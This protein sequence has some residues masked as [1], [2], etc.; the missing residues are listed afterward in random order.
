MIRFLWTVS[1]AELQK[2]ESKNRSSGDFLVSHSWEKCTNFMFKRKWECLGL[3]FLF[4]FWSWII[5]PYTGL[6]MYSKSYD[7][8]F[9]CFLCILYFVDDSNNNELIG[10]H[11]L[12][13]ML[14]SLL[15]QLLT[16]ACCDRFDRNYVNVDNSEPPIHTE[17]SL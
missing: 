4:L 11:I 13:T 9:Y 2:S 6:N 7:S 17:H 14:T 5:D 1:K 8:H 12:W 15:W 16:I 10:V 3:N